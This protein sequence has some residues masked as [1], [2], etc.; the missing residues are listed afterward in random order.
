MK[1]L[2]DSIA[3]LL[4]EYGLEARNLP[5]IMIGGGAQL[6]GLKEYVE[7]K[8]QSDTVTIVAPR[9]LG[10]RDATFTNALGLILANQVN[11]SVYDENHPRIGNVTRDEK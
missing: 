3:E 9:N 2:N 11:P 1:D 8:V 5:M 6:N 7:P 10:A 4:K